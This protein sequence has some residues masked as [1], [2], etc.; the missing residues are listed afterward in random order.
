MWKWRQYKNFDSLDFKLLSFLLSLF[1]FSLFLLLRVV[2]KDLEY[3][4]LSINRELLQY[5]FHLVVSLLLF[6]FVLVYF[7]FL[8]KKLKTEQ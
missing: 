4:V 2:H 1:I 6:T 5:S 3:N 8:W 7:Q